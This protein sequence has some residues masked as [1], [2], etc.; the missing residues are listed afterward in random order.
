M[1]ARDLETIRRLFDDYV[2]MYTSRDDR[3]T[4]YFS[5]DFSGFTGG[6]D[7]LVKDREHWIAITRQDFAQLK[8]P[9]EIELKDLA[10]QS[11]TDTIAVVT[12]FFVIHLPIKD[13]VLSERPPAWCWSFA[14][15]RRAGRFPTAAFPF[16]LTRCAT[17]RSFH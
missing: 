10:I 17:A 6:G 16:R 4:D 12:S 9:I 1:D 13:H 2:R 5:D 8:E 7:D 14:R 11:L 3:L 15:S